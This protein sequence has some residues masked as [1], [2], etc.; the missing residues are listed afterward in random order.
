MKKIVFFFFINFS[1][2]SQEF[3]N[4]TLMRITNFLINEVNHTFQDLNN[5]KL[6]NGIKFINNDNKYINNKK[7]NSID[8]LFI[9]DFNIIKSKMNLSSYRLYEIQVSRNVTLKNN[10]KVFFISNSIVDN[11]FSKKILLAYSKDE[12]LVL[13]GNI[14]NSFYSNKFK[15]NKKKAESY[16]KYLELKLFKNGVSN[17]LYVKKNK[18]WLFFKTTQ[19]LFTEKVCV[20]YKVN[21]ENPDIVIEIGLDLKGKKKIAIY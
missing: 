20:Y 15:L 12:I 1:A 21:K 18:D 14:P 9:T 3:N 5:Y 10:K 11:L 2:L 4:D 7:D 6:Y 13:S 17:I 16:I 19:K 8:S